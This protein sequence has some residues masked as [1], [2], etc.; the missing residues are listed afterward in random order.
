MM[1][2]AKFSLTPPLIEF[3]N[4]YKQYGFKDKSS[5]V[6]AALLLLKKDFEQ[7]NLKQSAQL[8]AEV[9]EEE[10]ELQELTEAATAGWPE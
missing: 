6:Q 10:T 2:Q 7:E 1:H 3:L 4:H 5:M 8:Y 9:Y